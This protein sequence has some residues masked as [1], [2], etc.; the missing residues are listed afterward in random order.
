MKRI[1]AISLTLILGL[2]LSAQIQ[3][4]FMGFTLGK[5][6]KSEVYNKIKSNEAFYE[7]NNRCCIS[8]V[9]F[10]GYTW[11]IA[12]F[13]FYDDRLVAV[14]FSDLET[15]TPASLIEST[16]RTIKDKLWNKY[17][18]YYITTTSEILLFSDN[19]TD[20]ALSLSDSDGVLVLV[21]M[22]QNRD[23]SIQQRA[24]ETD[25]L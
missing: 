3:N 10:A 14:S 1:L 8:N 18:K 16:W 25:E 11:D 21:L 2:S 7:N 22:Y 12:N 24:A 15:S 17:D 4:K 19:I 6:T 23:L 20:V 9:K 13:E 5:S